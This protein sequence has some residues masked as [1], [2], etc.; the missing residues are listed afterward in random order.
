VALIQGSLVLA[1][2]LESTNPSARRS[3]P[4]YR[5]PKSH[6]LETIMSTE[7]FKI[8]LALRTVDSQITELKIRAAILNR[9]SKIGTHN[10]IRVA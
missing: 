10:T 4:D 6:H 1:R 7:T 9:F 8:D 5:S 3:M 2:G